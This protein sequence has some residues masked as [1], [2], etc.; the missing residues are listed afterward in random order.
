MQSSYQAILVYDNYNLRI[1]R[2]IIVLLER[3]LFI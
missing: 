3:R 2:E 1:T